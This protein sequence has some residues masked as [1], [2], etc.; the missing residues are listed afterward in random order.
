M[1]FALDEQSAQIECPH[2][3]IPDPIEVITNFMSTHREHVW[4][5]QQRKRSI[6]D[7]EAAATAPKRY[8]WI[9]DALLD[10]DKSGGGSNSSGSGGNSSSSSRRGGKS[11]RRG[12]ESSSGGDEPML[13]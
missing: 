7:R 9:D 6:E 1:T 11:S 2:F 12:G 3:R 4:E 8:P 13:Q 5:M 10:D